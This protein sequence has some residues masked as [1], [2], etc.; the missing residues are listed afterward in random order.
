MDQIDQSGPNGAKWIEIDQ[1]DRRPKW[2]IMD[3]IGRNGPK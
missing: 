3:R 2:T 1:M